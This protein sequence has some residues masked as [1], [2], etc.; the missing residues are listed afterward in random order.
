MKDAPTWKYACPNTE[1]Q[2]RCRCLPAGFHSARVVFAGNVTPA[3]VVS[4]AQVRKVPKPGELKRSVS[5]STMFKYGSLT[6]S[7]VAT[8]ASKGIEASISSRNSLKMVGLRSCGANHI[9]LD[10]VSHINLNSSTTYH[11]PNQKG[12]RMSG[13]VSSGY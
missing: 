4:L 13:R 6:C 5:L 9:R 8:S 7:R 10:S 11:L 1:Y 12:H 3:T 2:D